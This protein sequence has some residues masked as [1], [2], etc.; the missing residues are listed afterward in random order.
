MTRGRGKL[1]ELVPLLAIILNFIQQCNPS[2]LKSIFPAV[3]DRRQLSSLSSIPNQLSIPITKE[4]HHSPRHTINLFVGTPPQLQ[5]LRVD[6]GSPLT[7]LP[8]PDPRHNSSANSI[9]YDDMGPNIFFPQNSTTFHKPNCSECRQQQQH[10]D[11]ECNDDTTTNYP[12]DIVVTMMDNREI[13]SWKGYEARDIAYVIGTQQTMI[14]SDVEL[15]D[16][17]SP[18]NNNGGGGNGWGGQQEFSIDLEFD[19]QT[20]EETAS[21]MNNGGIMGMS[22]A[23]GSIW[24]KMVQSGTIYSKAFSICL[25]GVGSEYGALTIGG[26]DTRLQ[27]SS[28]MIFAKKMHSTT[29]V[30]KVWVNEIYLQSEDPKND[31]DGVVRIH[32][33]QETLNG[34]D[35]VLLDSGRMESYFTDKLAGP[36]RDAWKENSGYEYNNDPIFL[37]DSELN[38]YPTIFF[39]LQIAHPIAPDSATEQDDDFDMFNVLSSDPLS[40]IIAMPPSHYMQLIA[41]TGEYQSQ[42]YVEYNED[43]SS[44]LGANF[45]QGYNILFDIDNQ[46]IGFAVS[47]CSLPPPIQPEYRDDDKFDTKRPQRP[48]DEEVKMH[49]TTSICKLR[50]VVGLWCA[51]SLAWLSWTFA[52]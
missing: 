47:D 3:L 35:G 1:L 36:F 11:D 6:T 33:D 42:F 17:S 28:P 20:S 44:T 51:I 2:P 26:V 34:G 50:A 4:G 7:A 25:G 10:E 15:V 40:V 37:S 12:C 29:G 41:E 16:A 52:H 5:T 32:I 30:F 23:E 38:A 31:D 43:G 19:C 22:D 45:M 24:N 27:S 18:N 13:S 48:Y 49:C 9:E 21:P 46:R 14:F 8:C 39:D